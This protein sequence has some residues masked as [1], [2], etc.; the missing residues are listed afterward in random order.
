MTETE[1]LT[2]YIEDKIRQSEDQYRITSTGFLSAPEQRTAVNFCRAQGARHRLYGGYA[3]AE[4][5]VLLLLPDYIEPDFTPQ[6]D[7]D[8]LCLLVCHAP[9]SARALSHRDYLGSLLALGLKREVIGDILVRAD[10]ADILVLK[11]IAAFL[12]D[13]Y[14]AA[15]S[16]PLTCEIKSISA[17]VPPEIRTETVRESVASARLDNML[18]AAFG[19]SRADA[20]SAIARGIVFVNDAEAAKPDARVAPGDKL[21]L[22][23][24]G[25]AIF[26]E[27]CGTTRKGRLSVSIR[28][29]L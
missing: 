11:S 19:I 26:D 28:K 6:E 7:D 25:K 14:K 24:H 10:G 4:R 22:R 5:A 15:G 17:L 9:A 27:I 3:D 1:L 16:V 21:V 29:F 12:A 2:A 8:P 20:I 18:S 13:E 23:G